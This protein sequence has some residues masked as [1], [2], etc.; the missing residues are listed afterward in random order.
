V[1]YADLPPSILWHNRQTKA[2]LV[3]RPEPRNCHGNFEAQITKPQLPVLRPKSETR[4]SGFEAKPQ[5]L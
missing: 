5:E 2:H 4:S 1:S 3:L